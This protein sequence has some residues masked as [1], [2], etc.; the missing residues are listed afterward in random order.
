MEID[1]LALYERYG[2]MVLRRCRQLLKDHALAKDAMHDV[3]VK[4]VENKGQLTADAPSALLYRIATNLCLNIIR[5]KKRMVYRDV[6]AESSEDDRLLERIAGIDDMTEQIAAGNILEKIFR[7]HP[8]STRT[9]AVMHLFD[10]MTLEEVAEHVGMSVSGVRKR[11]KM[12]QAT[13]QNL[14]GDW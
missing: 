14:Q 1:V 6:D 13:L 10:G 7:R 5:D 12:L 4:L 2:P 9:I 8:E 11:L 3:F